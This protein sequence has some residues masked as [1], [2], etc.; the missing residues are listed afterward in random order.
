M[1]SGTDHHYLCSDPQPLAGPDSEWPQVGA[2]TDRSGG[3]A[4]AQPPLACK[5]PTRQT[6][7]GFQRCQILLAGDSNISI[8]ALLIT[9]LLPVD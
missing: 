5:N 1:W 2:L 7:F 3:A 9:I 8:P 6:V 4:A